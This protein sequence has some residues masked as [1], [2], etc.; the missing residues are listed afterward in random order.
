MLFVAGRKTDCKLRAEIQGMPQNKT[1]LVL[2]HIMR[3]TAAGNL[4]DG[5]A[6][7]ELADNAG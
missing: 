2:L 1:N 4:G 3:D 6:H 7:V 5:F